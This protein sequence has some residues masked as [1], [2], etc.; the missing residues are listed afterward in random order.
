MKKDIPTKASQQ[1]MA[2]PRP[3]SPSGAVSLAKNAKKKPLKI[4][5]VK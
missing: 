4:G 3:A 2:Y 5:F 1:S